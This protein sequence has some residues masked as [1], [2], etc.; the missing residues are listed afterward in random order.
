MSET[1]YA[2]ADLARA[3]EIDPTHDLV[4]SNVL[5]WGAPALQPVA[6][7]SFLDGKSEDRES[8]RLTMRVLELAGTPLSPECAFVKACTRV[9]SP[10]AAEARWS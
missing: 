4:I 2:E 8:L 6:A 3:F 1:V 9:G 10:G 5:T 7:A